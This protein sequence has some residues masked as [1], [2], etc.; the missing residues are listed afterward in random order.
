MGVVTGLKE[1]QK[2]SFFFIDS[3]NICP[4]KTNVKRQMI[5]ISFYG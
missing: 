2:F 5:I 4:R 1:N 3:I